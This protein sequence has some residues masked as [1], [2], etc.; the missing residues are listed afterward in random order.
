MP[1]KIAEYL[2]VQVAE[3][4]PNYLELHT[5]V[6]EV[7][8]QPQGVLHGGISAFLA[9]EAASICADRQVNSAE[10]HVLGLQL[11]SSHLLPI[12]AGDT[13]RTV[14][15]PQSQGGRISVWKIEQFRMSDGKLFNASQLTV[16]LKKAR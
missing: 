4:S 9:E 5:P 3:S 12:K 11:N 7:M 14:T 15:T 16:Y 6:S 2:G 13:I 1:S 10:A 8:L